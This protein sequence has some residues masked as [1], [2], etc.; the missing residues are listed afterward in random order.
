MLSDNC[1]PKI[2]DFGSGI[3]NQNCMLSKQINKKCTLFLIKCLQT[4]IILF[5]NPLHYVIWKMMNTISIKILIFM[6]LEE[7]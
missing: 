3:I 1:L 2:I 7:F 5:P 4:A 6:L